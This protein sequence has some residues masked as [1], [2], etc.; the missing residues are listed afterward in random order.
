[1]EENMQNNL[2]IIDDLQLNYTCFQTRKQFASIH[3]KLFAMMRPSPS[4]DRASNR[5]DIRPIAHKSSYNNSTSDHTSSGVSIHFAKVIHFLYFHTHT[6]ERRWHMHWSAEAL[7]NSESLF[8]VRGCCRL[9][10]SPNAGWQNPAEGILWWDS[11]KQ[12]CQPIHL[13]HIMEVSFPREPAHAII[14]DAQVLLHYH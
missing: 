14:H 12:R 4:L 1:M 10:T 9:A 5:W 3:Y 11:E 6:F 2:S 7:W 8:Q 13:I